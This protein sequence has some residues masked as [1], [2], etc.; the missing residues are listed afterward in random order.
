MINRAYWDFLSLFRL[1]YR[2]TN[3]LESKEVYRHFLELCINLAESKNTVYW[4]DIDKTI[5]D[6]SIKS[7]FAYILLIYSWEELKEMVIGNRRVYFIGTKNIG[8]LQEI[9]HIEIL[10]YW[11]DQI[12]DMLWR[13]LQENYK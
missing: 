1:Y 2:I 7:F 11:S 9:Y 8:F 3:W 10:K 4:R 6:D 13:F 12:R 5:T